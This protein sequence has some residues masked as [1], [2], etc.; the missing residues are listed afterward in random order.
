[1]VS[2][3]LPRLVWWLLNGRRVTSDNKLNQL[4]LH[5]IVSESEGRKVGIRVFHLLLVIVVVHVSYIYFESK[6]CVED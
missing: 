1:M 4:N 3:R 5:V 6:S 2:P